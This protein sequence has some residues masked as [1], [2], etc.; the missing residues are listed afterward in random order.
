MSEIRKDSRKRG[1]FR[2]RG[3]GLYRTSVNILRPLQVA[4]IRCVN[5]VRFYLADEKTSEP[6]EAEPTRAACKMS[7]EC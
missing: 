5:V 6:V 4:P 3:H 1:E 2:I 7:K